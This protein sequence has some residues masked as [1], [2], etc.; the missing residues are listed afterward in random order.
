VQ[1][2][3]NFTSSDITVGIADTITSYSIVGTTIDKLDETTSIGS[4]VCKVTPSV[5]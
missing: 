5:A 4:S 2:P 1:P 3:Y